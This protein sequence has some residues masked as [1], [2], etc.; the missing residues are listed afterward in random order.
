MFISR[1]ESSTQCC[2]VS[3]RHAFLTAKMSGRC[4]VLIFYFFFFLFPCLSAQNMF[5]HLS[6]HVPDGSHPEKH[7][8][9][10]ISQVKKEWGGALPRS[11][12]WQSMDFCRAVAR[13][14]EQLKEQV[15]C[16]NQWCRRNAQML[17]I[18]LVFQGNPEMWNCHSG[19]P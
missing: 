15:S 14:M 19:E 5:Q 12:W 1:W 9:E 16:A 4:K 13:G 2:M 10:N 3:C 6:Y 18:L 17:G 7:T 11:C 8:V